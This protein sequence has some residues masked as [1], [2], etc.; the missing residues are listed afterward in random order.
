MLVFGS[1]L[2]DSQVMSLQT[3]APLARTAEAVIDPHNLIIKAYQLSGNL[4]NRPND[5]FLLLNDVRELGPLGFIIDSSEEI[6]SSEDVIE[7]GKL[8]DYGFK[9]SGIAVVDQA[10]HKIGTVQDYAVE[11]GSFTVQQ[12][13]VKRPWTKSFLDPELLIHRSQVVEIDNQKITI[14]EEAETPKSEVKLKNP[15]EDLSFVN[16]FRK[17]PKPEVNTS[18]SDN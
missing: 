3:G 2:A 1:K 4:L 12:L 18:L 13:I 7:L 6:V 11:T 5:S 8:L 15:I 9:L 14:R 17:E 10:G 16:P